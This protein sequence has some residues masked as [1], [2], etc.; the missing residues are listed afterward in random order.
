MKPYA[1][2]IDTD[3]NP[4]GPPGTNLNAKGVTGPRGA[5]ADSLA[6]LAAGRGHRFRMTDGDGETC[7]RGRLLGDPDSQDGFAPLDDFGMPNAGCTDIEYL[8]A[9]GEWQLL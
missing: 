5:D 6:A 8:D 3:C 4:D 9:D 1:W 7:Y 2:I